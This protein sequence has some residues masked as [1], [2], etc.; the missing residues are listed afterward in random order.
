[1]LVGLFNAVKV[2]SVP[3]NS[4]NFWACRRTPAV[5]QSQHGKTPCQRS[6]AVVASSLTGETITGEG[7]ARTEFGHDRVTSRKS[8]VALT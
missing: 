8:Q 5:E 4:N 7:P 2:E 6:F 1:M 3:L